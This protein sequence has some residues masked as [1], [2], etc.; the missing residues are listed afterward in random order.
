MQLFVL[1]NFLYFTLQPVTGVNTFRSTLERQVEGQFYSDSIAPTVAAEVER[2]ASELAA[3]GLEPAAAAARAEDRLA[4]SFDR[5]TS[6]LSR[7]LLFLWWLMLLP[8]AWVLAP[9]A[10]PVA[11]T[12]LATDFVAF[13]LTAVLLVLPVPLRALSS[14][15][16]S[17]ALR[18]ALGEWGPVAVMAGWL[19]LG[20]RR[21]L[22]L[23]WRRAL[24]AGVVLAGW[25]VLAMIAYRYLLFWLTWWRIA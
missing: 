18:S 19:V 17:P 25:S 23:G 8:A 6:T 20:F 12:I 10:G 22:G 7:A 2:R 5:T 9:R 16:E 13:T 14:P 11:T 15:V 4:A 21:G 1:A 24:V 3:L